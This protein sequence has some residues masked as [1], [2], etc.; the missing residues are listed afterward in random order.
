MGRIMRFITD[1]HSAALRAD[2]R[3][4]H[5]LILAAVNSWCLAFDNLSSIRD[6]LADALCRLSTGGAYTTRELYTTDEEAIFEAQRPVV[7]TSIADIVTRPDLLDRS[8]MLTLNPIAETNRKPESALWADLELA[9]PRILGALLTAVSEALRTLPAVQLDVLPRMADFATWAVA[10][11]R[12]LGLRSGAF[13]AAYEGNRGSASAMALEAEPISDTLL[14]FFQKRSEGVWQGRA[15][16]LLK[17]LDEL[18]GYTDS[19]KKRPYGWPKQ[20]NQLS[21]VLRRIAPTLRQLGLL[22][23]VFGRGGKTGRK[24]TIRNLA[25]KTDTTDTTDIMDSVGTSDTHMFSAASL[26][27]VFSKGDGEG[28]G[29]DGV[30][31]RGDGPGNDHLSRGDDGDGVL[32]AYSGKVTDSLGSAYGTDEDLCP[33]FACPRKGGAWCA[34]CARPCEGAVPHVVQLRDDDGVCPT[35]VVGTDV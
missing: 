33:P 24:I 22:D 34:D 18:A 25:R 2:P 14:E 16:D 6:W 12:A 23:I 10:G 31:G 27:D 11:E 7:I 21:G 5:D 15:S 20:P 30:M 26:P 19:K 3:N 35:E 9:R 29:G 4:P 32:N 28:G 17:E 13:M 1:P 8:I